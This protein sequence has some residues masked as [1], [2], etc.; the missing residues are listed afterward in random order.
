[1]K[2]ISLILVAIIFAFAGASAQTYHI[3]GKLTGFKSN[4]QVQMQDDNDNTLNTTLLD[5]GVFVLKG[6][7]KD[8]PQYVNLVIT[9]ND[10]DYHCTVFAGGGPVVVKGTKTQFPYNLTIYWSYRAGKIQYVPKPA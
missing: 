2:K 5:K 8:G 6:K 10:E 7:L 4:L 9:E 1:M 3:A